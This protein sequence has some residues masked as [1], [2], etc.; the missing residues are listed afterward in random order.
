MNA[1]TTTPEIG[2]RTNRPAAIV[3]RHVV[4][5]VVNGGPC[6]AANDCANAGARQAALPHHEAGDRA[7]GDAP[8]DV[9]SIGVGREGHCRSP[10]RVFLHVRRSHGRPDGFGWSASTLWGRGA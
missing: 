9:T 2:S 3:G 5:Q 7:S 1:G 6:R 10:I 4:E 8:Y